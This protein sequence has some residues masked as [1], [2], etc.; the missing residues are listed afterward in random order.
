M[1]PQWPAQHGAAVSMAFLAQYFKQEAVHNV[2]ADVDLVIRTIEGPDD[3]V[4]APKPK[5]ARLAAAA[6]KGAACDP[7]QLTSFPAHNIVLDTSEYFRVQQ[8]RTLKSLA[9]N[10]K[11]LETQHLGEPHCSGMQC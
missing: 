10:P 11:H 4:A 8:V 6:P 5:R 2:R 3:G 9:S 1:L 7:L